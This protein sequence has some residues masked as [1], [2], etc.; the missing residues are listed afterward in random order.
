MHLKNDSADLNSEECLNDLEVVEKASILFYNFP[1]AL[2]I[3]F[4]QIWLPLRFLV[5]NSSKIQPKTL[6]H[7]QTTDKGQIIT[8]NYNI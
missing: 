2:L 1:K 4:G 5:Y 8:R 7:R 6:S 3:C